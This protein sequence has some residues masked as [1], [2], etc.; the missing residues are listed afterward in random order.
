MTDS[1]ITLAQWELLR[2]LYRGPSQVNPKNRSLRALQRVGMVSVKLG[3]ARVTPLG[4]ARLKQSPPWPHRDSDQAH[5]D[6][7][8]REGM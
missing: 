1:D 2:T 8:A 4:A 6:Y 7:D 5:P 3:V